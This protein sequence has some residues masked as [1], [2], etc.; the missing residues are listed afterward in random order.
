[1]KTSQKKT[2]SLEESGRETITHIDSSGGLGE[3]FAYMNDICQ[4]EEIP[5]DSL[6][7]H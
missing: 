6:G 3:L 5:A 7:C 4:D 2:S 1:M